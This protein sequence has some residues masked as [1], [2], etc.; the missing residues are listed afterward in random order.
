M[1]SLVLFMQ[2]R[3]LQ[4]LVI[5]PEAWAPTLALT[6][7]AFAS[8]PSTV[9]PHCSWWTASLPATLSIP[10]QGLGTSW[11]PLW[12][13]TAKETY[14]AKF[15]PSS[16]QPHTTTTFVLVWLPPYWGS[17]EVALPEFQM[18]RNICLWPQPTYHAGLIPKCGLKDDCK[19]SSPGKHS[20]LTTALL[21][22]ERQSSHITY[23]TSHATPLL[24]DSWVTNRCFIPPS[25][26]LVSKPH[27]SAL[28]LQSQKNNFK[29]E[30]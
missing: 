15:S 8:L 28:R 24:W 26:S 12:P 27:S 30:N 20:L 29:R 1:G 2:L 6:N 17:L 14:E 9:G 22:Q 4:G 19:H 10:P 3:D 18:A 16:V 21:Q 23:I 5:L 7:W 25:P 13:T 11:Y